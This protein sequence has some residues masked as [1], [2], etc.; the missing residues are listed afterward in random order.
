MD[1]VVRQFVIEQL[2]VIVAPVGILWF[3]WIRMLA[4]QK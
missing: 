4:R 1:S 3:I 2:L